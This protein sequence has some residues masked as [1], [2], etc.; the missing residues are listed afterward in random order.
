MA[1]GDYIAYSDDDILHRPGWLEEELRVVEAF[2]SVGMVSGLPTWQNCGKY[3]CAAMAMADADSL[4]TVEHR[5]PWPIEWARDYADSI[6]WD[7]DA[8]V[9]SCSEVDVVR[10]SRQGVSALVTATHCQFLTTRQALA[11]VLPIKHDGV[12]MHNVEQ[13]DELLDNAGHARLSIN[14]PIVKHIGNHVSEDVLSEARSYGIAFDSHGRST[15][16]AESELL[17]RILRQPLSRRLVRR[18][19]NAAFRLSMASEGKFG[20]SS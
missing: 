13:F 12:A 16:G 18:V 7:R 11:D 1:P 4:V 15:T 2:S 10:I 6:G 3:A 17:L 19:H 20:E 9:R 8:Y 14:R 5:Q